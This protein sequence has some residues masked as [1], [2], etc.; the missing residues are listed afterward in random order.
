MTWG[1]PDPGGNAAQRCD[2]EGWWI[3]P[4]LGDA[5]NSTPSRVVKIVVAVAAPLVAAGL[6]PP[7]VVGEDKTPPGGGAGIVVDGSYCTL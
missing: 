7:A 4:G 1:S 2:D 6:L 3:A 5:V